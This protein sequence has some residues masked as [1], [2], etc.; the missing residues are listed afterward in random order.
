MSR[1]ERGRTREG[2]QAVPIPMNESRE[3]GRQ[4]TGVPIAPP[5]RASGDESFRQAQKMESIGRLTTGIAHD[6]NNLL[7]VILGYGALLAPYVEHDDRMAAHLQ[8]IRR[9]GESAAELTRQLL[10]FSRQEVLAPR[11]VDLNQLVRGMSGI[12]RRLVGEDIELR[13]TTAPALGKVTIDAGQIEQVLL[14]LVANARDAMPVGGTLALETRNVEPDQGPALARDHGA[15]LVMLA[16]TDTGVGMDPATHAQAFEPFFTTKERGKGTGLGLAIV[17]DIICQNGGDVTITSEPGRGTTARVYLPRSQGATVSE[18]A[19]GLET[20]LGWET[21]LLVEDEIAV[22]LVVRDILR[23][24]GYEVLDVASAGEA[25]VVAERFPRPIHLLLTDVVMPGMGGRELAER[26]AMS[27]PDTPVLFTSGHTDET[28]VHHGL[29]EEGA[30][31]L[32]KPL[33]PDTL[34]RTIRRLLDQRRES[35]RAALTPM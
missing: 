32:R 12:F 17:R 15:G 18:P 33:L 14:N 25:L 27:R 11:P 2:G 22:R 19:S 31:L 5:P 7:T 29:G 20:P 6:F 3:T 30:P 26:M 35:A 16:V 9:A 23:L 10:A 28:L 34:K 21:I 24:G 8:Q 13:T 4:P 1:L